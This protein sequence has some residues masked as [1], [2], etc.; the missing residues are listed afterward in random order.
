VRGILETAPEASRHQA[1][2]L[3]AEHFDH[4]IELVHNQRHVR[5]AGRDARLGEPGMEDQDVT[6]VG[7]YIDRR[8]GNLPLF[9]WLLSFPASL[10]CGFD[11]LVNSKEISRIELGLHGSKSVVVVTVAVLHPALA[12]VHHE[13]DVSAAG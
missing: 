12:F 1:L 6:T 13:I 4:T 10:R 2:P 5:A 8:L 11:V 3:R 7:G 9:E